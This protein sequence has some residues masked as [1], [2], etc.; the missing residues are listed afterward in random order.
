MTREFWS[1]AVRFTVVINRT[2]F[3]VFFA[4]GTEGDES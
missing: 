1:D 2:I 3:M 4:G